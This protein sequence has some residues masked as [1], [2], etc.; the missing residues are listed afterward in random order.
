MSSTCAWYSYKAQGGFYNEVVYYYKKIQ[1]QQLVYVAMSR[2]AS[3][4]GFYFIPFVFQQIHK[5]ITMGMGITIARVLLC[6]M[7]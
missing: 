5:N 4:E 6:G 3:I 1:S 2:V 7:R